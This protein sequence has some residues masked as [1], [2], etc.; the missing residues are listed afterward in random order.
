MKNWLF[1]L[2]FTLLLISIY[3]LGKKNGNTEEKVTI[4]Q[5]VAAIT[6]IAELSALEAKG[7]TTIKL[8]NAADQSNWWSSIKNYLVENTLQI[9]VPYTA[10]FGV[11]MTQ[12]LCNI[13]VKDSIF[14]NYFAG[15]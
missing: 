5:N 7:T 10:K 15:M 2:V 8:S 9:T 14:T 1:L 3:F 6:Q 13:S 11:D 4:I 12:S